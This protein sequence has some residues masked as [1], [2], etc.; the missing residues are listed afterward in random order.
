MKATFDEYAGRKV[1]TIEAKTKE[2]KKQLGIFI[3]QCEKSFEILDR[4]HTC[5]VRYTAIKLNGEQSDGGNNITR[6]NLE[7]INDL[8]TKDAVYAKSLELKLAKKHWWQFW[9]K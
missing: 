8:E 2:E 7:S 1:L 9:K 4:N 3:R 6:V 5:Y